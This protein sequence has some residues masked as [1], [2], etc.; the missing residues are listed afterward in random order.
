MADRHAIIGNPI[1]Q[2]KSP[3]LHAAA[4]WEAAD[5]QLRCSR[6]KTVME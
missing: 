2:T 1:S 4:A 6:R 3:T 5:Q